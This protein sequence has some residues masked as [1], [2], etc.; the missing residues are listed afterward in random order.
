MIDATEEDSGGVT[1]QGVA[2]AGIVPALHLECSSTSP[3]VTIHELEVQPT[4]QFTSPT[5]HSGLDAVSVRVKEIGLS[6]GSVE[7]RLGPDL[8]RWLQAYQKHEDGLAMAA[9]LRYESG[10]GTPQKPKPKL[11]VGV[12]SVKLTVDE[13][14]S[15]AEQTGCMQ[16]G[17]FVFEAEEVSLIKT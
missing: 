6:V 7:G 3:G 11:R 12:R 15:T 1:L 10:N 4:V 5:H 8:S 17:C 16:A 9:R 13:P 2:V 14:P